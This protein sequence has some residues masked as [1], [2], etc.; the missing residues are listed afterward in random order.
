MERVKTGIAG[1]DEMLNGGIPARR[2]V[3]VYGGPGSGKT[4]VGFEFLYRGALAGENGLYITLEETVDDIEENMR[5]TF[6]MMTDVGKLIDE[7]KLEILKPDRLE[8]EEVANVLEDR[9]TSNNLKRAVIDSATMIKMAFAGE[10]EYRQTLF[11]FLSLLRNLDVTTMTTVEAETSKREDLR[12]NIEHFVMD[13]IINLYNID[14]E[15]RRIRAL[16]V[17]KMRGTD[18]SRDLTPFKVTPSGIK[19]YVGEKVF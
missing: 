2:H 16:E 3:A 14:R 4:S 5:G 6:P 17:F 7:K 13:G 9:I 8:M 19:V 10:L 11:E 15:D 12:Y 1:L 18:H